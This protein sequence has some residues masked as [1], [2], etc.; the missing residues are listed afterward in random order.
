V[1]YYAY[2]F[3]VFSFIKSIALSTQIDKHIDLKT[4][5]EEKTEYNL[6][7]I[8]EDVVKNKKESNTEIFTIN[9]CF[10]NRNQ[11]ILFG[12]FLY[13]KAIEDSLTYAERLPQDFSFTPKVNSISQDFDYEPG[14]RVG[15]IYRFKPWELSANWMRYYINPPSK[16]ASDRLFGLLATMSTP[17]WGALGNNQANGVK[18]SWE[19]KM[20]AIDLVIRRDLCFTNFNLSPFTGVKLGII[21]Q[22]IHVHYNDFEDIL[23]REFD[24]TFFNEVT[25]SKVFAKSS[26]W[27]IG[28]VLGIGLDYLLPKKFKIFLNATFSCLVGS[29]D[30]QTF[31]TSFKPDIEPSF[32]KITVKGS[33]TRISL[34][35][36]IQAGIDKQWIFKR[37][38]Y[39]EFALGWEVQVWQQ[40]MRLN[41]FSTFV[42]TPSGSDLS[43]YGPFFRIQLG[44]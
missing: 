26:F 27:G 5:N 23:F 40:Q 25:P 14:F 36:Q 12:D 19:L 6:I 17:V 44:F 16:H 35:K 18:G 39:L 4:K 7:S 28:P 32:S 43:L 3:F 42:S 31:Y 38:S 10:A 30:T 22:D 24:I 29:F 2:S 21:E 15:A 20:D 8:S 33:E 1:N 34:V 11:F 13:F 37:G 41:Y 9:N